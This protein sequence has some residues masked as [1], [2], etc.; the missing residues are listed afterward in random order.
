MFV[1]QTEKVDD[2]GQGGDFSAFIAREGV[3]AAPRQL[4]GGLL[5]ESQFLANAPDLSPLGGPSLQHQLVTRQCVALGASFIEFNIPAGSTAKS[6]EPFHFRGQTLVSDLKCLVL[7]G[8]AA[9]GAAVSTG[10]RSHFIS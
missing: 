5:T 8:H 3:V 1:E 4:G 6:S 2:S 10:S 7:E 9:R